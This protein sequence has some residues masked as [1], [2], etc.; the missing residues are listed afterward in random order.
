MKLR[1]FDALLSFMLGASWAFIVV[2][3]FVT[4]SSFSF[5]G[6]LPA[7]FIT[8]LF[9]FIALLI[10]LLLEALHMYRRNFEEK[11]KQTAL[12]EKIYEHLKG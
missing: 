2:G 1:I 11:R 9:I 8:F 3:A 12:L 6:L 4:Y 10:V 5:L 7:I